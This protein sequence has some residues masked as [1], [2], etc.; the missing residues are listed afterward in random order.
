MLFF[1]GFLCAFGA[2]ILA[3]LIPVGVHVSNT[4]A[5]IMLVGFYGGI[6]AMAFSTLAWMFNLSLNFL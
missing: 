1:T 4:A 5:A 2:F 6:A 3:G